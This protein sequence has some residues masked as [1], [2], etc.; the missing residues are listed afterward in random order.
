M[1]QIAVVLIM[2]ELLKN[3]TVAVTL[4]LM[5]QDCDKTV[6]SA[7]FIQMLERR[8]LAFASSLVSFPHLIV[9]GS[10][11]ITDLLNS[12]ALRELL[13]VNLL[14]LV[15]LEKFGGEACIWQLF[16]QIFGETSLIVT[17]I[18]PS[19]FLGWQHFRLLIHLAQGLLISEVRELENLLSP[20]SGVTPVPYEKP[21]S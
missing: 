1:T 7:Q 3:I 13:P 2:S 18:W 15:R 21:Q 20:Y 11:P 5:T 17:N 9:P 4:A 6:L 12:I 14:C 10:T 19:L 16:S 8:H